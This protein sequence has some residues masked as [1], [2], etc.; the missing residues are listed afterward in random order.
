[1]RRADHSSRGV[2][3]TVVCLS[4]IVKPRVSVYNSE[5]SI[6]RRPWPNTVRRSMGIYIYIYIYIMHDHPS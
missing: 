4:I 5:A 3:P 6:M 1:V 2:L